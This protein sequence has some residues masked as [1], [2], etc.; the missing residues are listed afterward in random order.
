MSNETTGDSFDVII[1]GAGLAGLSCGVK[2]AEAGRSITLLE[3]SD[4]VGGRVRTDHIDGFT[5]DHG[6][7]VLLTAYPA[8]REL[9]DY[10]QLEL[11]HFSPGAMVRQN[12]EFA[13]LSDPW[14]RPLDIA[15]TAINPVGSLVDKCR[16][17]KLRS[18]SHAGSL[19]DVYARE[20]TTTLA[21][22]REDGFSDRIIEQFFRPF[23]GGVYLDESLEMPSRML[24]FV[25]RMFSEGHVSVPAGGMAEIPRQLTDRLPRGTMQLRTPVA[26]LQPGAVELT[27]GRTLKAKQIVIATESSAAAS[28][29]GDESLD[30]AWSGTTTVYYAA[31][32]APLRR[33]RLLLRGD[34]AGPIQTATVMSNIAP[35]YAPSGQHLISVSTELSQN[36]DPDD[37]DNSLRPQLQHWFGEQ[38]GG[39]KR[40]QIY[41]VPFGLPKLTLDPVMQPITTA[42]EGVFV[43]GDHRET[44]SIQGAMNSGLRVAQAILR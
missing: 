5:L 23:L 18:V 15:A 9:L 14:R 28:L 35:R 33:R 31:P 12:G 4:R 34:E 40:L 37:L 26:G 16:I 29:L 38:A 24:E 32:E 27:D 10:K 43:C 19:E 22:L 11:C 41:H 44:P 39:W 7:Q 6:F 17:S 1:V 2:L 42:R 13:L 8:C 30:T 20:Q 25:F 21:R 3:A 36:I